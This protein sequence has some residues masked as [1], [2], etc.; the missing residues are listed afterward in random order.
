MQVAGKKCTRC[1]EKIFLQADGT[2]C[3]GWEAPYHGNCINDGVCGLCGASLH[4]ADA[5]RACSARCPEC[6]FR[7]LEPGDH[8]PECT[9]RT[10]WHDQAAY[11]ANRVRVNRYG[12]QQIAL[13]ILELSITG[14]AL[15]FLFGAATAALSLYAVPDGASRVARGIRA[16]RFH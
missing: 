16:S 7:L 4:E 8:C 3:R 5:T 13:G 12:R 10:S 1:E 2:W 15:Y 14:C 11:E 6:G 9:A